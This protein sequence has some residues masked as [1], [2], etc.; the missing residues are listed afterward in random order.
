MKKLCCLAVLACLFFA[1]KKDSGTEPDEQQNP[2]T[3]SNVVFFVDSF[4]VYTTDLEGNGLKAIIDEDEKSGDNFI[5]KIA[6]TQSKKLVYGYKTSVGTR[7]I[8]I[9]IANAD[10]SNIKSLKTLGDGTYADFISGFGNKILYTTTNYSP[11]PMKPTIEIRSMNEDGTNDTKL[12]L[13][14]PSLAA[15]SGTAYISTTYDYVNTPNSFTFYVVRFEN[16]T[17]SEAKSFTLPK[18]TTSLKGSAIS[19]D[20]N[21]LVYVTAP[22][23]DSR[24]YDIYTVDI[25]AKGNTAKKVASYTVPTTGDGGASWPPSLSIGFANGTANVIV[26]YGV[27]VD[28]QRYATKNDYYFVQNIDVAKGAVIKKWKIFGEYG[29]SLL[30]N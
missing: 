3:Q 28:N 6:H 2:A 1:C 16:G 5:N 19:N 22:N 25:S 13:P 4:R 18:N 17:W 27:N 21:T 10:G 8:T 23:Y 20:G 11:D 15:N 24:D 14:Q 26:G 12:N 7:L 9:K 30:T 29:G